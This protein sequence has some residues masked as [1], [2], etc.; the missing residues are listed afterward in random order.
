MDYLARDTAPFSDDFWSKLDN[1][2]VE[3]ARQNLTG[4]KFLT[5]YGPLGAGLQ[6]MHVDSNKKSEEFNEADGIVQTMGRSYYEVPQ[7]YDDFI[8]LWR[9]IA[10]SEKEDYPVDLS[11]AMSCAESVARREDKLIFFG[12]KSLG[13]S[14]LANAPGINKI[15][16]SDWTSGEGAYQDIAK[17]LTTLIGKGYTGRYALI[18]S[19][20]VYLDLQRIQPGTGVLEIDRVSK[21]VGGRVFYTSILGLK[22]A[23]LVCC[24]PQNMD[25]VIGQDMAAAYLELVDLNHHFRVLETILP[26]LKQPDAVV[27]FE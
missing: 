18:L 11:S 8:L 23:L 14:G 4:R 26:R 7:V 1:A 17:G 15:K 16:R 10:A 21:M 20:D 24:E 5:I 12:N 9:D 22:K 3:S 2:V 27:S 13:I 25:L 6:S 19:P